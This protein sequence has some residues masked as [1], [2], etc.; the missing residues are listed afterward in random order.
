[1]I[2]SISLEIQ[3]VLHKTG[4][5]ESVDP[6]CRL[7]LWRSGAAE[8]T[9]GNAAAEL[10]TIL[11]PQQIRPY[12][13]GRFTQRL[14]CGRHSHITKRLACCRYCRITQRLADRCGH[15]HHGWSKLTVG[16]PLVTNLA[17]RRW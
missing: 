14:A 10:L 9:V 1:M 13:L 17:T 8:T 4:A 15:W 12:H 6:H 11:R 2:L 3:N 16:R 7:R 5:G